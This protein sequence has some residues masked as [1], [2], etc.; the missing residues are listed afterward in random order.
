MTESEATLW[1][2]PLQAEI[3]LLGELIAAATMSSVPLRQH[4][5]DQAL[6]VEPHRF[7]LRE[8]S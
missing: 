3:L 8:V 7:P 5:I 6:G 4:E 2:G 1:D